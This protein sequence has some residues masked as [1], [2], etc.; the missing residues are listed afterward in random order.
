M[1]RSSQPLGGTLLLGNDDN[2]NN[3][4]VLVVGCLSVCFL[5]SSSPFLSSWL[6]FSSSSLSIVSSKVRSFLLVVSD[7]TMTRLS[8]VFILVDICCISLCYQRKINTF[9]F[10]YFYKTLNPFGVAW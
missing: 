6:E 1:H 3:E 5:L 4:L 7:R 9:T 10:I 8:F 2:D